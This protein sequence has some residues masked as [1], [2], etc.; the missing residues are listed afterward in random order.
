MKKG[1]T[2]KIYLLMICSIAT[3]S[4]YSQDYI[5][6]KNTDEIKCKVVEIEDT[7]VKYKNFDNLNGPIYSINKDEIFM[8]KYANGKKETF[9]E[10]STIKEEKKETTNTEKSENK[11]DKEIFD[12]K[13]FS[14]LGFTSYSQYHKLAEL[15]SGGGYDIIFLFR[16]GSFINQKKTLSVTSSIVYIRA[17]SKDII[18]DYDYN[19][20]PIYYDFAFWALGT[21]E[22]FNVHWLRTKTG[23]FYS[24]LGLGYILSSEVIVSNDNFRESESISG[25]LWQFDIFGVQAKFA[26][27]LGSFVEFG[28]GTEGYIK[29]GFQVI[30]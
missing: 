29:A 8:I 12:Y 13:H 1:F 30:W 7:K 20:N 23:S 27:H 9:S 10:T 2:I 25:L 21:I 22:K 19:Y 24:G 14:G 16:G 4:G 6:K 17:I 28:L 18:G 26:K 3:L 11:V 5:V 15:G